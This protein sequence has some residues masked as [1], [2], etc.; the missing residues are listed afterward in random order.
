MKKIVKIIIS[1]LFVLL[2]YYF[3][4][5]PIN[6]SSPAFW[7]F[8]IFVGFFCL[9]I[10]LIS[11]NNIGLLINNKRP[12]KNPKYVIIFLVILLIGATIFIINIINMPLFNSKSYYER[13]NVSDSDFASNVSEVDFNKLALIDKDSST[14]LG[15]RV[16]GQMTD[17]VSQFYVSSLYT[18]VSYK[19]SIVRVTP[20]EYAGLIKYFTNRS[21]GV[22][23]YITVDSVT[24]NV[25][26]VRLDKGMKYVQSAY[27]FENLNRKLRISYPTTIFGETSFEI[28]DEGNPYWVT[29][30]IK[31]S[32]VGLK[33]EVTGVIIL[34]PTT[35]ESEK[36]S[37]SETPLWVDHVYSADLIIDQLSDWGLYKNGF[38]NSLFGQKDVVM[39]TSGYNYLVM[40]NNVYLYTGITSVASD[41]SNVGFILTNL[42]TKETKFY[43]VAGA[44]EYSAMASAE[45]QVQQMSY[46]A[47]FPLLINLNGTPTY[48]MSLKD[49]AGLVKMYAFVD[50]SNYQKVTVTDAS[51][52]IVKAAQKYL[53][54]SISNE[55][56]VTKNITIVY[57]KTAVL[58]G[59]TYYYIKDDTDV[60]RS[61]IKTNEKM[62][63]FLVSGDII[64]ITY[65]KGTINE[66]ISIND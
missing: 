7:G 11:M 40:D 58:D 17:L 32:G 15:D 29:Q 2:M 25:E 9:I 52:G 46:K 44:E 10:S 22:K 30:T 33:K 37:V 57:I 61:S 63:P 18:Q 20:L 21:E 64:N 47:T 49:N 65:S 39:T 54:G 41:Q 14:K 31:Y 43:N 24:G 45:G 38:F 48:L 28:D 51:E 4:L 3:I 35:G 50:Y 53:G 59:V 56:D 27:F 36:Y 34:N 12:K 6:L 60:Y 26:L 42:R 5:P 13:I 16:M 8:I 23:G 1:L 66:I 19:D 55:T 62:L